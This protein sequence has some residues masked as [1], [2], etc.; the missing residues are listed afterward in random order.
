MLSAVLDFLFRDVL[1]MSKRVRQDFDTGKIGN[2]HPPYINARKR[3]YYT[4][5][6]EDVATDFWINEAT[7]PEPSYRQVYKGWI[8]KTPTCAFF[9]QIK[10][11]K[12]LK[13]GKVF[14]LEYFVNYIY[15]GLW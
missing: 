9:T 14:Y 10:K 8:Q 6:M 11:I 2:L 12:K 3:K 15:A 1:D 7:I 13:N 4:L 5:G